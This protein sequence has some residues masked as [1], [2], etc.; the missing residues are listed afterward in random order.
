M[1]VVVEVLFMVIMRF[2]ALDEFHILITCSNLIVFV[3][4]IG[5]IVGAG[6]GFPLVSTLS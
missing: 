6:L 3:G 2:F 4:F 5:S 1:L